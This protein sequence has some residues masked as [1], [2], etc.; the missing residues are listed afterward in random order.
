MGTFFHC[1][2]F[3]LFSQNQLYIIHLKEASQQLASIASALKISDMKKSKQLF[4][5]SKYSSFELTKRL[6]QEKWNSIAKEVL[7]IS[8]AFE[9]FWDL[10]RTPVDETP[11]W[12]RIHNG[13]LVKDIASDL[14]PSI[15]IANP[16]SDL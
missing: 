3:S 6:Y 8:P 9:V 13:Y 11:P 10:V 4:Q 7:E 1:T 14:L 5:D 12:W 2:Y 16:H 15:L